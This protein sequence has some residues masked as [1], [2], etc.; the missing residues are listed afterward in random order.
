[1]V[2]VTVGPDNPE[3]QAHR[4]YVVDFD[5]GLGKLSSWKD[6]AWKTFRPD[7]FMGDS[8]EKKLQRLQDAAPAVPTN[9][10]AGSQVEWGLKQPN[11]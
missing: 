11:E 1:M 8:F 7:L 2:L 6:Y 9:C 5:S 10:W 3:S 4:T